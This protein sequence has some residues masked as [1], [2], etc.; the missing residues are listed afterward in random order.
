MPATPPIRR[1]PNST[2]TCRSGSPTASIHLLFFTLELNRIDDAVLEAAM[3]RSRARPLP[4]VDRGCAQGE[5]L[6]ARGPRRAALPRKV[7]DRLCGLE[8]AVRRDDR[9]ACA[10]RSTASRWRSSRRSICCRTRRQKAQGRRARRSPRRSRRTCALHAD[11]QHARQG[12]GNL[13]PLARLQGR[14]RRA[15]SVEPRRAAKWS[16][17][18]SRR[19]APPIRGCRTAITR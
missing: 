5:A 3:A 1:A 14:R 19:C 18:W 8:P 4:A 12:Q 2:A 17:R 6:P 11:H 7:G 16:M 9:R 15:P 10:S 13:R